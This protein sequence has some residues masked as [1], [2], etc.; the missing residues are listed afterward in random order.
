MD[1]ILRL[2]GRRDILTVKL[3]I[4]KPKSSREI[5]SPS[6]TVQMFPGR[7]NIDTLV[8]MEVENQVGS[9]G[10]LVCGNGGLSDDVR[11]VCRRRQK[12]TNVDYVEES[13][14]W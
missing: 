1:Q 10:V 9:M 7:P 8:G 6:A 4:S 2:P 14:T 5:V 12:R 13:F 3:F 11:K